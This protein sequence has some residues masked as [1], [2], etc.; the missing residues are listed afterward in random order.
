MT[1]SQRNFALIGAAGYIA[2]RHLQAIKD[3]GNIL[4]AALDR[5]DSVG[6][7][8]RYFPDT[9]F[10]TEFERFDRHVEKLRRQEEA[11]RVHYVS[12]TS[13]NYLHDAHIRFALRIGADAICEKPLVLNPWNA[14]AL[15]EL[16]QETGKKVYNILQLR[17]HPAIIA[18]KERITKE[19]SKNKYDIELTYITSRGLWYEVSWKGDI[20]K[21]G[22]VATNIG[23][24]FFDMLLWIFGKLQKQVV[25]IADDRKM[26]GYFE[27]E[28]AR[29]SWFLSLDSSD[30]P[31]AAKDSGKNTY[32]T[33]KL[34][35][36]LFEFSEGFGDLHTEVYRQVLAGKGFGIDDA[37][38]SIEL[39]HEI[40][41]AVPVGLKGEY[42]PFSKVGA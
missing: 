37:R 4:I 38:A 20:A 35:D 31:K 26:S 27:L 9:A 42:H 33:L 34:N 5:S 14:D 13:P 6:I 2:P 18:L 8:D 40:R 1:T 3:T 15:S 25:H 7:L 12:I 10:F 17:L 23:I 32:R 19:K 36:E 28:R 30:L 39:A 11:K 24:H 29:V 21:S 16:E 22:G 41:S